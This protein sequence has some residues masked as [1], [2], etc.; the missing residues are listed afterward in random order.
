MAAPPIKSFQCFDRKKTIVA[1]T[2]WKEGRGL[3]KIYG[4]P[5]E[6][7]E[8]EILRFKDYEP[9]FFLDDI[10]SPEST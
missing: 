3:F 4:C 7:V 2:Y 10:V 9:I 8:P 6:H 5:I 1:V